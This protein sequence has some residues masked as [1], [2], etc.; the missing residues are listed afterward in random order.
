[1]IDRMEE[2]C[3][4]HGVTLVL[5]AQTEDRTLRMT[6]LENELVCV[7]QDFQEWI[8]DNSL[9]AKDV[10]YADLFRAREGRPLEHIASLFVEPDG[11]SVRMESAPKNSKVVAFRR[12]P[13]IL[14][15][16]RHFRAQLSK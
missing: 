13:G 11:V 7:M 1:M 6:S 8:T 4:Q 5:D 10:W 16:F 15:R 9:K 3:R 12:R 2:F 14:R